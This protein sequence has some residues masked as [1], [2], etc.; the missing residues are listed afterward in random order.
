MNAVSCCQCWLNASRADAQLISEQW[1]QAP[2]TGDVPFKI[3]VLPCC[4]MELPELK[5]KKRRPGMCE[6]A[7]RCHTFKCNYDLQAVWTMLSSQS[8]ISHLMCLWCISALPCQILCCSQ[9][10]DNRSY[11]YKWFIC[12]RQQT[13]SV[14]HFQPNFLHHES[15]SH[16]NLK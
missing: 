7:Q 3:T 11:K 5:K 8:L 1:R 6:R 2:V 13:L 14:K 15:W 16:H 4:G 9:L 10:K 12:L